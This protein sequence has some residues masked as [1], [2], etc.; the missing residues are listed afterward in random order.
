MFPIFPKSSCFVL[1]ARENVSLLG[2][3]VLENGKKTET[4]W[5]SKKLIV[6][7]YILHNSHGRDWQACELAISSAIVLLGGRTNFPKKLDKL[8]EW[9]VA[10]ME[11]LSKPALVRVR[12]SIERRS[13]DPTI[14]LH[15]QVGKGE[16]HWGQVPWIQHQCNLNQRS[17]IQWEYMFRPNHEFSPIPG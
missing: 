16:I 12:L 7:L 11:G 5:W 4:I 15:Y 8:S 6:L 17:F 9:D 10:L 13:R 1:L 2:M 14:L 3:E